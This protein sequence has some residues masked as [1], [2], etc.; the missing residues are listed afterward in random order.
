VSVQRQLLLTLLAALA[1]G[2]AGSGLLTGGWVS[3]NLS[4]DFADQASGKIDVGFTLAT[5]L[6]WTGAFSA[7]LSIVGFIAVVALR[8]RRP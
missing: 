4:G 3:E 7:P 2:A 6:I 1:L 5:F 8:L